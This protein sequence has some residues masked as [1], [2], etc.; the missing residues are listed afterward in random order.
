MYVR[1]IIQ[2]YNCSSLL[3]R[4]F[5]FN[6]RFCQSPPA[7]TKMCIDDF[8]LQ[9]RTFYSGTIHIS[10]RNLSYS[11]TSQGTLVSAESN[12]AYFLAQ[13]THTKNPGKEIVMHSDTINR[14][15]FRKAKH[16][17]SR[18]RQYR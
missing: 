3:S 14:K 5:I 13:I 8:I 12:I 18:P 15:G 11:N 16:L 7:L 1:S 2:D 10:Q 17:D 9:C 6:W 4:K